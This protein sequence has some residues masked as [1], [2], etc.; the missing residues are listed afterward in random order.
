VGLNRVVQMARQMGITTPLQGVPA[1]AL[2]AFEVKPIELV[3]VYAT[4]AAGGAKPPVHGL[5]AVLDRSEE[6]L[7]GPPR[8]TPERALSAGAAYLVTSLLQGV[9]DHGTAASVRKQGLSDPLAG[10]TGTT[11]GRRDSWFGGFAPDRATVVWVGYDDNSATRLSG[12]RAA[13]PIWG[14]F[15]LGVRP[16]TGY[17]DFQRP[18]TIV[19]AVI[20]PESAELATEACPTLVTEIFI[21]RYVPSTVCSLHAGFFAGPVDQPDP[22]V[23]PDPLGGFRGWL[24]KVFGKERE[25]RPPPPAPPPRSPQK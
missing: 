7:P 3:T 8:E 19:T 20:D 16:A 24:R 21:D 22:N 23:R 4:L 18:P 11:N 2:G 25:R 17:R 10:K 1:L 15:M 14:R 6:A 9:V 13:V 12:G 5:R